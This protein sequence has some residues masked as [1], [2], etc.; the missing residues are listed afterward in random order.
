MPRRKAG[1]SPAKRKTRSRPKFPTPREMTLRD[2]FAR[3]EESLPFDPIHDAEA[4]GTFIGINPKEYD[5]AKH[6]PRVLAKWRYLCA[7]AMLR[8]RKNTNS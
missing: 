5:P 6:W 1:N 7:D 2:F 3:N 4:I 8:E